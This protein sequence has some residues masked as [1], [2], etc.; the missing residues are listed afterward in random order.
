M[1]MFCNHLFKPLQLAIGLC[2]GCILLVTCLSTQAQQEIIIP[3]GQQ[4]TAVT[5]LPTQGTTAETV[6]EQFGEP[7]RVEG[8]NGKPPITRWYFDSFSVYFESGF[9]LHSVSHF[10]RGSTAPTV[11]VED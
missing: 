3:I 11:I 6:L 1:M 10:V 2:V 5:D 7:I 9:V 8:P 4:Q